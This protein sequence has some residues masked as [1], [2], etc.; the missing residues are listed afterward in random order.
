[1]N[2]IESIADLK[3]APY[4]PR[5]ISPTALAD[6]KTAEEMIEKHGIAYPIKDADGQIMRFLESPYVG[7]RVKC[8]QVIQGYI[9]K[10]V[11]NSGLSKEQ[12]KEMWTELLHDL[13]LRLREKIDAASGGLN[14]NKVKQI[15]TDIFAEIYGKED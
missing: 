8:H 7:L 9:N 15:I 6:L 5:S 3:P 4:N 11:M 14:K 1:M 2:Q 12:V 10:G 13:E